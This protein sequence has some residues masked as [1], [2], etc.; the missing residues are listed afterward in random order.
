[1]PIAWD[2]E[3]DEWLHRYYGEYTGPEIAKMLGRTVSSIKNRVNKLNI[4]LSPELKELRLKQGQFKKGSKPFNTGM[5]WDDF[6]PKESQKR[7]LAT[8]FKKG[9]LPHNTKFDNAISVRKDKRGVPYQ[10]IRIS[11]ANWQ[12]LHVYVY[13][14]HHGQVPE[15]YNVFFK[16]GNTMDVSIENLGLE[17]NAENMKRNSIHNYPEEI[18]QTIRLLTKIKK[19]IN[20]KEQHSGPTEPSI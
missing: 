13:K 6:M 2:E 7:S 8:T 1:M 10:Y 19:I 3:E 5:K 9:Q 14:Q 18:K 20:G 17:T 4:K 11:Q 15:G 12:M 16:N